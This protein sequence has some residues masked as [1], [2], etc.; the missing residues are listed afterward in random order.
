M[1][2]KS[3]VLGSNTKAFAPTKGQKSRISTP[4]KIVAGYTPPPAW[5]GRASVPETLPQRNGTK[6][7]LFFFSQKRFYALNIRPQNDIHNYQ[8]TTSHPLSTSFIT[9]HLNLTKNI[10]LLHLAEIFSPR[11]H[12][13][14]RHT[15][16]RHRRRKPR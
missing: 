14:H 4:N 2:L 6:A 16:P 11:F 7:S 1:Q 3:S 13:F 8:P 9:S 12:R 10:Y 15:D 5:P